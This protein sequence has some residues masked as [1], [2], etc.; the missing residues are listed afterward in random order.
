MRDVTAGVLCLVGVIPLAD[1]N[2]IFRGETLVA[3]S[4]FNPIDDQLAGAGYQNWHDQGGVW[5]R[6]AFTSERKITALL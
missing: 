1:P 3:N 5:G 2:I 6:W 4:N